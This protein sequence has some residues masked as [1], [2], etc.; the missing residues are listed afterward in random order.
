MKTLVLK[1]VTGYLFCLHCAYGMSSKFNYSTSSL[2][3]GIENRWHKYIG[4]VLPKGELGSV[5]SVPAL[6]ALFEVCNRRD[7][8]LLLYL[9]MDG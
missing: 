9:L 8:T 1:S 3:T 4:L 5:W 6:Q 7:V 2:L